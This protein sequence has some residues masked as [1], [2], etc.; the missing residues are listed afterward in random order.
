MQP[1]ADRRAAKDARLGVLPVPPG[2]CQTAAVPIGTA[3]LGGRAAAAIAAGIWAAFAAC[4]PV[5]IAAGRL[6]GL[7][8]AGCRRGERRAGEQGAGTGRQQH[9]RAGRAAGTW[10]R[11]SG[12]DGALRGRR[13]GSG[14]T[15]CATETLPG[16][17]AYRIS[18][19][20]PPI[21]NSPEPV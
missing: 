13:L 15:T 2:N 18:Q 19:L 20:G 5:A 3:N 4:C 11:D 12:G 7:G 10:A 17:L 6:G 21:D 8:A 14:K 1:P 9:L 16:S